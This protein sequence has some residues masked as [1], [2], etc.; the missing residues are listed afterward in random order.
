MDEPRESYLLQRGTIELLCQLLDSLIE[1]RDEQT[2]LKFFDMWRGSADLNEEFLA[3]AACQAFTLR[4]S[5]QRQLEGQ[6]AL[7]DEKGYVLAKP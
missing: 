1:G 2:L 6:G 4:R 5:I 3:L 7:L